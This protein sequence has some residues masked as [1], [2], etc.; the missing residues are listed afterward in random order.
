MLAGGKVV[1]RTVRER[2]LDRLY[3]LFHS[4]VRSESRPLRELLG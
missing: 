2:D 1:I 4:T 3:D